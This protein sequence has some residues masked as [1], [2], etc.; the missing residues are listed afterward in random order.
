MKTHNVRPLLADLNVPI[1]LFWGRDERFMPLTGI[2]YFF[3]ACADVR[4]ITFS[5]VGH[6]VQLERQSE[7]NLYSIGFL[8]ERR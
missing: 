7:F 4:C 8:N 5:K 3:E 1:L 2:D 6:W